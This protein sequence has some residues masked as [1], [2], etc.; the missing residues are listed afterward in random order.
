[1]LGRGYSVC[2]D[3]AKTRIIRDASTV[4]EGDSVKVTLHRGELTAKVTDTE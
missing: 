2:W 4:A 1:V 3:A